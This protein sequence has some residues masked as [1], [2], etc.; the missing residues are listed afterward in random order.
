MQ[1]EK[2]VS[3]L[4][5]GEKHQGRL[6]Y[7][8]KVGSGFTRR[9]RQDLLAELTKAPKLQE[10]VDCPSGSICRLPGWRCRVRYFGLTETGHLRAPTFKGLV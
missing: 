7:K 2:A 4:L 9:Q 10:L 8:G 5:L 3:V 1:N 6:V